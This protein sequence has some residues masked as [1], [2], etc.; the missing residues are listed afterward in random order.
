M[1]ILEREDGLKHEW[2]PF[3]QYD[4]FYYQRTRNTGSDSWFRIYNTDMQK[5]P[6]SLKE[7]DQRF[8]RLLLDGYAYTGVGDGEQAVY[9]LHS[10]VGVKGS[11][12]LMQSVKLSPIYED[13]STDSQRVFE[14]S[15]FTK[16]NGD[17][18]NVQLWVHITGYY[19]QLTFQPVLYDSLYA[20]NS[21]F[22]PGS[23]DH[24]PRFKQMDTTLDD[25]K[26]NQAYSTADLSTLLAGYTEI[27]TIGQELDYY[28]PQ[29]YNNNAT[30]YNLPFNCHTIVAS[31]SNPTNTTKIVPNGWNCPQGY[32]LTIYGWNAT[33]TLINGCTMSDGSDK[34]WEFAL[35]GTDYKIIGDQAIELININNKWVK[36]G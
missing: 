20:V 26:S 31:N 36:V 6:S 13:N 9:F 12:D 18:Y 2:N 35:Q 29:W 28:S 25:L 27:N 16:K 22:Y 30:T 34:D 4:R 14:F 5:D 3:P 32:K 24:F 15:I 19:K 11:G 23:N 17:N 7:R 33:T 8:N 21:N 10:F 1:S